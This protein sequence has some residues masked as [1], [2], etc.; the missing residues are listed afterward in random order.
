MVGLLVTGAVHFL[1]P[2]RD[3]DRQGRVLTCKKCGA[4]VRVYE[5]P[6]KHLNP[7]NYTC[8]ECMVDVTMREL[9]VPFSQQHRKDAAA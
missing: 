5:I 8:G 9:P 7:R 2:R 4:K 1:R 6:A 3:D